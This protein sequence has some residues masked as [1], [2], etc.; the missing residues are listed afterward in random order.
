MEIIGKIIELLPLK[1]G[2]SA[3]GS[4][5][6]QEYILETEGQYPKKVCFMA[7]GDKIDEFSIKQG[8]HLTVSVDIESREYNG[9]WYTDIKAWQVRRGVTQ[10]VDTP[11]SGPM[12]FDTDQSYNSSN[13]GIDDEIPF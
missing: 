9:R 5:S 8:E 4:W 12:Q 6:K 10:P 13:P 7:W 2:Q 11:T 1:S 3:K